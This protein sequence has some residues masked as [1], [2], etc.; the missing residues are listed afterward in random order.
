MAVTVKTTTLSIHVCL[1]RRIMTRTECSHWLLYPHQ[2][3]D[4]GRLVAVNRA[5]LQPTDA[6][7]PIVAPFQQ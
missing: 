1:Q 7:V 3:Q 4:G 5:P 6:P 2:F